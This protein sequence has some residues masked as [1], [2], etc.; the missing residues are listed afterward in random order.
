MEA[1]APQ[2]NLDAWRI[3]RSQARRADDEQ[4]DQLCDALF[5]AQVRIKALELQVTR[6]TKGPQPEDPK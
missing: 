4:I 3:Q 2:V 6:L 5:A 1:E